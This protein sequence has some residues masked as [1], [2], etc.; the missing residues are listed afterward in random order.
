MAAPEAFPTSPPPPAG[1]V[2]ATDARGAL[3]QRTDAREPERG[4]E[5]ESE[6]ARAAMRGDGASDAAAQSA[7][8]EAVMAPSPASG[9]LEARRIAELD[10]IRALR[11]AGE[12]EAARAALAAWRQRWPGAPVP[13]DLRPLAE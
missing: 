2:A 12:L 11:D 5:L 10:H 13:D 7:E 4:A 9:G 8:A 1:D 3:R 6:R